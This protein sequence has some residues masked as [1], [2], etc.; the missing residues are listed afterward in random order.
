[1]VGA[2]GVAELFSLCHVAVMGSQVTGHRRRE[3]VESEGGGLGVIRSRGSDSALESGESGS[4]DGECRQ[5]SNEGIVC[6][7]V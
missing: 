7:V 1:M 6:L 4:I 2:V 3:V 5:R